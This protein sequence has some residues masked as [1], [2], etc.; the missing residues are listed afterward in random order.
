MTTKLT[1]VEEA[2]NFQDAWL[3]CNALG[4]KLFL[5]ANKSEFDEL[6]DV[7]RESGKCNS[8][9]FIGG[10]KESIAAFHT[11]T[12]SGNEA[13]PFLKWGPNQPNGRSMQQ[14]I[15]INSIQG[16]SILLNIPHRV[17]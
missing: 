16:Q 12:E 3:T 5:P 8:S 1:L 7:V 4:G 17:K 6:K 9:S 15:E 13:A 14:C 10:T 11:S 2:L